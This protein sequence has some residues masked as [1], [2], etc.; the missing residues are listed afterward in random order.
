TQVIRLMMIII[1]IPLIV[2]LP[3]FHD[4]NGSGHAA[5]AANT[6]DMAATWSGM[7]PDVLLFALVGIALA[8]AGSKIRFPTAV[9]LGPAIG[10]ALIQAFGLAG[11]TLP[12]MLIN[13]AQLMIGTHVGLMLQVDQIQQKLRTILLA[14]ASGVLL[15]TG[16]IVLSIILTYIQPVSN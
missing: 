8:Y 13:L 12:P 5:N 14:A 15:L 1:I 9:L 2:T 6:G 3:V 7:F 16:G 10:T 11:P 4:G